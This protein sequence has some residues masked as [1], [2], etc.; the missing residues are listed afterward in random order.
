[1]SDHQS[2]PEEVE[3]MQEAR[4]RLTE[5]Q[6]AAGDVLEPGSKALTDVAEA[7]Q[8][9]H[10]AVQV[11]LYGAPDAPP[12]PRTGTAFELSND[13]ARK[14]WPTSRPGTPGG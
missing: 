13:E 7:A 6:E 12:R 3:A 10:R 8:A 11:V 2:T 9:F 14:H 5:A 4:R 1:M